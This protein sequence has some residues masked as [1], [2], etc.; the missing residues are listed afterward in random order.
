MFQPI[1]EKYDW[2]LT[3]VVSG[4]Y[5]GMAK[6]LCFNRKLTKDVNL[7]QSGL[8]LTKKTRK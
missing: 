8:T 7:E 1:I 2:E 5:N 6:E 3:E 4:L